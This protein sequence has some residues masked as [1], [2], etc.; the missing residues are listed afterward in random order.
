[1]SSITSPINSLIENDN[2]NYLSNA[3]KMFVFSIRSEVTRKYYERRLRHFFNHINF[4]LE[5]S[6]NMEVRCN[7]F[8][9]KGKNDS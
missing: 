3:Y 1:M 9:I 5:N 6:K 7:N 2:I 8:S 4:D